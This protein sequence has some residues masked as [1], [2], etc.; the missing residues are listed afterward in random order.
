MHELLLGLAPGGELASACVS[1]IIPSLL[2]TF[3]R[4]LLLAGG[5]ERGGVASILLSLT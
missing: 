2:A 1:A 5:W 4:L 3:L